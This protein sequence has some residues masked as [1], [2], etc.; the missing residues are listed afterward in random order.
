[1]TDWWFNFRRRHP[2]IRPAGILS[3]QS[4]KRLNM[5]NPMVERTEHESGLTYGLGPCTYDVRIAQDIIIE[6]GSCHLISLIEKIIIPNDVCCTIMDKSTWARK[7]LVMQNTHTD[8]GFIGFLT[9]EV[10]MHGIE[11]ITIIRGTPIAQLK[12]EWLDESTE[13]PYNGQYQNQ[14]A[15][16]Q[17][18]KFKRKP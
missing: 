10:T 8:P 3:Y 16:P 1:M 14:R 17:P 11:R 9:L 6:S 12:F 7:F 4:I 5:I 2:L 18:A 15:T 13:Q